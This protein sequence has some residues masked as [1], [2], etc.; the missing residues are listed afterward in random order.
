M[1]KILLLSS[2]IL[3]FACTNNSESDKTTTEKTTSEENYT[4]YGDSK[5]TPE[6]VISGEK[7]IELLNTQDSAM[8]KVEGVISEVCS[9]KGC[10][11]DVNIGG[12][13]TLFV[14]FMDYGFFMP[15]DAAG[16]TAI[17]EGTAKIEMQTVEWLKH[18]EEDAGSSQEVIDAITEPIIAYSMPEATGVILK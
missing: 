4:V 8:V 12:E 14:R 11:M 18:K 13:N 2:T 10:W 17:I 3:A 5:M 6:G 15:L 9:K 7:L 16:T 1:K